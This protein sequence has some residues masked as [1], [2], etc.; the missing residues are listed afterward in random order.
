MELFWSKQG[1]VACVTHAPT[2]DS[3]DWQIQGWQAVPESHR[4]FYA[5]SLQCQFCH[6]RPYA[7][8]GRDERSAIASSEL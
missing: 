8:H 2:V 6:G 3:Q 7:H 5:R 1:M 4:G